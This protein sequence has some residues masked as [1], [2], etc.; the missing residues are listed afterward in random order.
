VGRRCCQLQYP[1]AAHG[2]LIKG[3]NLP[4]YNLGENRL[5]VSASAFSESAHRARSLH[6]VLVA[7]VQVSHFLSVLLL[8]TTLMLTLCFGVAAWRLSE[9]DAN[10]ATPVHVYG[11]TPTVIN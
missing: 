3:A 10:A 5:W 8:V 9:D 1:A 2:N 11:W 7:G 6:A 4:P